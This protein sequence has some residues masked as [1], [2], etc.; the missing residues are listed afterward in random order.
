MFRPLA[1]VAAQN[2]PIVRMRTDGRERLPVDA[3]IEVQ[4][5]DGEQAARV[6]RTSERL[7]REG[8]RHAIGRVGRDGGQVLRRSAATGG[9]PSGHRC[10]RAMR[11]KSGCRRRQ[12]RPP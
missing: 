4:V 3:V 2:E 8:R 11:S 1:D 7:Y 9:T 12:R 10:R 5:A 6:A